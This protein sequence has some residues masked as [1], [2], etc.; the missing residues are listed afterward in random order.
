MK[1]SPVEHCTFRTFYHEL[2]EC[3]DRR[4]LVTANGIK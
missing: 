3:F 1:L 4:K 2:D